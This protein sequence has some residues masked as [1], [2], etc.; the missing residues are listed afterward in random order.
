[1]TTP[2][3]DLCQIDRSSPRERRQSAILDA[4]ESLFLEQGY[5]R[6]SL[7]EIVKSSGGS[8]ATLYELFGNKQGLLHAIATRWCDE[9]MLRSLEGDATGE[10]SS[11]ETLKAYAHRQ[12]E[13]MESP[14][15]VAL[16]RMLISESLR[17]REFALQIYRDL[18]VPALDE[19]IEL[20]DEWAATGRA[21]IDDPKA[22]ARLFFDIVVGD[23]MLN[24]L[25]GVEEDWLDRDQIDWRL[26]PFLSHFKIR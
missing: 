16:M 5:E 1:M 14:R 25:M 21:E 6:T 17:D 23:S 18:H 15:A 12:S 4:A 13:L 11:V 9:A 3:S 24:T 22:A 2:E 8:L 7:A 19:L 20:F 26:Q 10:L